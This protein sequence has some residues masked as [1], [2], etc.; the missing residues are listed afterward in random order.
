[1]ITWQQGM[2]ILS[3][4]TKRDDIGLVDFIA[5][6]AKSSVARVSGMAVFLTG[7]PDATTHGFAAQHQAQQSFARNVILNVVTQD[8]PRVPELDRIVLKRLSDDFTSVTIRFGY[9][10]R[11]NVPKALVACRTQGLKFD[12]M[13]TSFFLFPACIAT[14]T[15]IQNAALARPAIYRSCQI[16]GQ[17]KQVLSHTIRASCRDRYTGYRLKR[18]SRMIFPGSARA[19]ASTSV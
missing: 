8:M 10:E 7:H 16:V 5:M 1:M 2:R 11:P 19:L 9:M 6:M 4:V 14:S 3:A 12:V 17:C 13:S 18:H 15:P